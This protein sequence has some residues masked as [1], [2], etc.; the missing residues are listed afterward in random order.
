MTQMQPAYGLGATPILRV[1]VMQWV[2]MMLQVVMLQVVVMPILRGVVMQWVVVMPILRVVMQWN[3]VMVQLVLMQVMV[4]LQVVMLVSLMQAQGHG[5]ARI[6]SQGPPW[7]VVWCVD[8]TPGC[9][10]M[11]ILRGVMMQSVVVMVQDVVLQVMVMLQ[12][13]VILVSLM[14]AQGH[15]LTRVPSQG[16]PWEVVW[17]VDKTPDGALPESTRGFPHELHVLHD[18]VFVV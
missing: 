11:P 15:G 2:M 9:S 16:R 3:V 1:V 17:C 14:K 5:L 10:V 12:V 8:K 13:I 18:A 6:P 7:E 4:M